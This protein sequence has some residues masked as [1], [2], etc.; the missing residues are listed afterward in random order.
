MNGVEVVENK[1]APAKVSLSS[2]RAEF[3][4][5]RW[6]LMTN[7]PDGMDIEVGEAFI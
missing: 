5:R 2:S 6:I 7:L 1:S 4:K 3:A